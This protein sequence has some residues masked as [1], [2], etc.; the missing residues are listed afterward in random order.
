MVPIQ[1]WQLQSSDAGSPPTWTTANADDSVALEEPLEIRLH[2]G[3]LEKRVSR[4]LSVTMRTPGD[5]YELAVGFLLSEGIIRRADDVLPTESAESRSEPSANVVRVALSADVPVDLERLQ[6]HFYTT[7]SC[8]L[9]GK[10]SLEALEHQGLAPVS[11]GDWRLTASWIA[12]LPGWLRGDQR[13]FASTGGLHASGLFAANG[14]LILLREDVGRHN[15]LDKVL[16]RM[17]LDGKLP[18]KDF[19]LVVSGRT[20]LELIQKAVGAGIPVLAGIGAPS[21]LAI[22]CAQRFGVTLLGFVSQ[23]RFNCYANGHRLEF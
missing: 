5:D 3:P 15:A 7:S 19:V 12:G 2:Y 1:R 22:D 21:S 11:V 17:L 14:S 8:G 23:S 13:A 9:C 16:G 4:S 6:R 20:S 18:L 10:S